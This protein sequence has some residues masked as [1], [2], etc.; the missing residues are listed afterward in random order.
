VVQQPGASIDNGDQAAFSFTVSDPERRDSSWEVA[1]IA[2]DPASFQPRSGRIERGLGD[3]SVAVID[4]DGNDNGF[5]TFEVSAYDDDGFGASRTSTRAVE[6]V[7]FTTTG[8]L[9]DTAP[10][11]SNVQFIEGGPE[12]TPG[13]Q[14]V[15]EFD[16]SDPDTLELVWSVNI[17]SGDLGGSLT[18]RSGRVTTGSGHISV[19]YVD[20]AD[21][22]FNPVVFAIRVEEDFGNPVQSDVFILRVEKGMADPDDPTGGGTVDPLPVFADDGLFSNLNGNVNVGDEIADYTIFSNGSTTAPQ[23]FRNFDLSDQLTGLS[24]VTDISHTTDDPS[25]VDEVTFIRNFS[26]PSGSG[27]NSGDMDFLGYVA[28]AG[29][30][31]PVSTT[32]ITGGV[33]R[34]F[35]IFGIEA[36]RDP[37][38][39]IYNLPTAGSSRLYS[40]T[41][42]TNDNGGQTATLSRTLTVRAP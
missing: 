31:G 4:F 25:Q 5:L 40:I 33:S 35:K 42:T 37:S 6:L 28:V 12:G 14:G 8:Q 24:M 15:I 22:P 29:A 2:G 26:I 23:L 16:I 18:P 34:W 13:S 20:D 41:V 19:N 39:T 27:N 17:A 36:F 32:P 11:I 3:V 7:T 38:T 1:R 21:T 10:V 30:P 9:S